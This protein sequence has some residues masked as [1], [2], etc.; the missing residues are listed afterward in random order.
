MHFE[1]VR[2]QMHPLYAQ[3]LDLYH[4]S[5][6]PHERRSAASQIEILHAEEYRFD[7]IMDAEKWVGLL[8]YWETER[9]I[10]V[11]HFCICPE[12]RGRGYG[13]RA[14]EWIGQ[15]GKTVILE[16]DPPVDTVSIRRKVFYEACGYR[17]NAFLHVHPPY[18]AAYKGHELVVMSYPGVLSHEEYERFRKYLEEMVMSGAAVD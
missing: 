15:K 9:F 4:L 10:Y 6:P 1:C 7:L 18:H 2:T 16:I 8:L 13:R 14:L 3:A 11:E 12:L 5:F 17:E